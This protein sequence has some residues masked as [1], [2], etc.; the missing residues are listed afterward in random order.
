MDTRKK[1]GFDALVGNYHL[2][3]AIEIALAGDHTIGIFGRAD[4]GASALKSVPNLKLH[5]HERCLCGNSQET[6]RFCTCTI[7]E[8]K[9][10]SRNK[11]YRKALECDILVELMRP[12]EAEYGFQCES[13]EEMDVRVVKAKAVAPVHISYTE[14]VSLLL[15]RA[16]SK[17]RFTPF[18]VDSVKAIAL[19]IA[20]LENPEEVNINIYVQH[21]AEAIQYQSI[22]REL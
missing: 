18:Q 15:N 22:R 8:L 6:D 4:N 14:D 20:K 11:K 17:L 3:R 19:T 10:Y 13:F 9:R 21:M 7:S 2:R 5:F 16:I 1:S 12:R